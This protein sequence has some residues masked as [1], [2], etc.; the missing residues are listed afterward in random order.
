MRAGSASS[1]GLRRWGVEVLATLL[2]G[3][4]LLVALVAGTRLQTE[5][6]VLTLLLAAVGPSLAW[7]GVAARARDEALVQRSA[8]QDIAG[9]LLEHTARGER[10]RIAR[11][12]HDVVA[13][14]I[15]MV[16]VQAE[17]ARLTTPGMPPA[18]ADRLLAI[19]DTARTALTEMRR[20]LGVLREEAQGEAPERRPQSGL[21]QLNELLDEARAASGTAVRLILHGR[22]LPLDPVVQL[23]A[24]R[25]VQEA[26]TNARRHA[27]GAAVD[28]ELYY[29]RTFLVLR[30]RDNG[31]GPPVSPPSAGPLPSLASEARAAGHGL[32]G[33]G[34]RAAAVGGELHTGAAAGKWLSRGGSPSD[35]GRR[36]GAL[37]SP[38][39]LVVADDH[40]VVRAGFAELLDT[41]PD[42][43]VVGTASDGEGAV[44]VCTSL[45]PDVVLMDVRMPVMDGI[46]AT[47]RLALL[48]DGAPHVII[49][50]T[51]DLDDYVYDALRAG[52]SGFLLKDVTAERLF[53]AV[54]V[55]AAGDALLGPGITRRLISEFAHPRPAAA[56]QAALSSLTKRES[57]VLLLVA[58][59]LSNAEIAV[60]LVVTEETV[61][62]HVSRVLSK[63]GLR[64]RTQA[65]IAAYESGLVVP[66]HHA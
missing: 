54:R 7:V 33:M 34:E 47:R 59:G 28:V 61:K 46:E 10:A 50:T 3:I 65:V 55:V 60:R 5:A 30:I 51:F 62:T 14:H 52:A 8:R 43:T 22:S 39:R 16:A 64:D 11:E 27:P 21:A 58:E 18:G 44:R 38:V 36:A 37:V 29:G 31:P 42:F 56:G 2:G 41:Q 13:H 4:F 49:L 32:A 20:L 63:L 9:T 66:R 53:D 12:L 24:Y 17:T 57:E 19:A 6:Y 1:S 35:D 25:I 48:G 15:S 26:L 45:R 40:G 23:A